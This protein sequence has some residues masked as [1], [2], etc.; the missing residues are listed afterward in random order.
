M[1]PFVAPSAPLGARACAVVVPRGAERP[2]LADLKAFLVD[3]RRFAVWKVPERI[4]FVEAFPVTATG[5]IQ[6]FVLRDRLVADEGG[7]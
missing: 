2:T 3:D 5:K 1:T 7:R 6:K 4:E